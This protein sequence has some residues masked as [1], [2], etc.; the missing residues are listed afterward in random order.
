MAV[1]FFPT[2]IA[3]GTPEEYERIQRNS[4]KLPKRWSLFLVKVVPTNPETNP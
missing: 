2:V 3:G 1:P 4:I